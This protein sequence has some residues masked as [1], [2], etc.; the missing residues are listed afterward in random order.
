ME[1]CQLPRNRQPQTAATMGVPS[2]LIHPVEGLKDRL[3]Q[4]RRDAPA[5]VADLYQKP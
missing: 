5:P 2:R 1:L 3:Q 4:F